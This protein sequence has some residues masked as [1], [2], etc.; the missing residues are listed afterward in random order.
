MS[1]LIGIA[2]IPT[3]ICSKFG[4]DAG[5][6]SGAKLLA[7]CC[8]KLIINPNFV[9]ASDI[10]E[11]PHNCWYVEGSLIDSMLEGLIKLEKSKIY[12][13]ILMVANSPILPDSVN[14]MNAGIWGLGAD[15]KLLELKTPLLMKAIINHDG[16]AGGDFSGADELID[17]VKDLDFDVLAVHTP[18][19]CAEDVAKNYW[20]NGGVNPWGQVE[21]QVSKYIATKLRKN[22]AHAPIEGQKNSELLDLNHT[23]IVSM[24]MAPEIISKSFCFCVLKG[25]HKARE[26]LILELGLMILIF[27]LP[28]MDVGDDHIRHV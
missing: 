19:Q 5:F 24:T 12:N 27:W 10:N 6:N 18:I 21:A 11:A 8:S 1:N 17:Q 3:G 7:S 16:T 23:K 2:I 13:K 26:Y 4:G 15:I 22:I 28:R 25:L 20:N 9:N 14:A